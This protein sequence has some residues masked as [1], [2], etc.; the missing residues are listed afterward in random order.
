MVA[1]RQGR[2]DAPHLGHIHQVEGHL[3]IRRIPETGDSE[4]HDGMGG[5]LLLIEDFID[6]REP[7]H[8]PSH[9]Q[10]GGPVVIAIDGIVIRSLGIDVNGYNDQQLF[11][12]ILGNDTLCH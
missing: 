8:G 4:P 10:L 11:C 12:S 6:I 1:I 2:E 7:G 9:R 5:A 3:Q